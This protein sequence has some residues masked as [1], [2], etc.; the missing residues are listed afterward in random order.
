MI[1]WV[2]LSIGVLALAQ[3]LWWHPRNMAKAREKIIARQG[4]P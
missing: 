4:D 1:G 3:E 2:L